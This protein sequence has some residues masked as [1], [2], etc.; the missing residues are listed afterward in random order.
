MFRTCLLASVTALALAA[1]PASALTPVGIS[2]IDTDGDGNLSVGEMR[3]AGMNPFLAAAANS[4]GGTTLTRAERETY[5]AL[6]QLSARLADPAKRA[7]IVA[8][9]KANQSSPR[10]EDDA[11]V[12]EMLLK[13]HN[14]MARYGDRQRWGRG[15]LEFSYKDDTEG[16]GPYIRNN[17]AI[18]MKLVET[19]DKESS[20]EQRRLARVEQRRQQD[21]D[22]DKTPVVVASTPAPT[23]GDD[24]PDTSPGPDDSE[25]LNP[26]PEDESPFGLGDDPFGPGGEPEEEFGP[27]GE[28]D[29]E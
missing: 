6:V 2:Q 1:L 12:A 14:L 25:A 28:F 5:N 22:D 4:D 26:L 23:G 24:T 19:F 8:H 17:A 16:W 11:S 15:Y 7:E 20:A 27:G 21:D 29:I 18:A 3:A 13:T 9:F 10:P